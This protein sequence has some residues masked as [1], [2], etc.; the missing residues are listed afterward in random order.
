MFARRRARRG[1]RPPL[2]AAHNEGAFT[3]QHQCQ[4]RLPAGQ[5]DGRGF[6]IESHQR[7]PRAWVRL[8]KLGGIVTPEAKRTAQAE[9][10]E[11]GDAVLDFIATAQRL[12]REASAH[13]RLRAYQD[14]HT[15]DHQYLTFELN[16]ALV[17]ARVAIAEALSVED[18]Q[19]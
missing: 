11:A 19:C 10:S 1:E 13:A 14:P 8:A 3:V 7:S 17:L 6:P 16:K 2:R 12:L 15:R 5:A 9:P 18:P 4:P